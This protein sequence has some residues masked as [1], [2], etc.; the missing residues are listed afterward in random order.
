MPIK[1]EISAE[2]EKRLAAMISVLAGIFLAGM[3]LVIGLRRSGNKTFVDMNISV[4]RNLPLERSHDITA[5]IEERVHTLVPGIDVVVHADPME[6]SR[7]TMVERIRTIASKRQLT[8][9]NLVLHS[10]RKGIGLDLHLEVDS[11]SIE[12]VHAASSTL[13]ILLKEI[14][15]SVRPYTHPHRTVQAIITNGH[16]PIPIRLSCSRNCLTSS[17]ADLSIRVAT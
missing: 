8:V 7:E 15:P 11:H 14:Y 13:E 3:K 16:P 5:A 12:A 1:I 4:E 10:K 9:H 6:S 2:A 17:G